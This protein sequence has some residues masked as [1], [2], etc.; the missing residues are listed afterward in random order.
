M[1]SRTTLYLIGI[2]GIPYMKRV[3]GFTDQ[4]L[5]AYAYTVVG[6]YRLLRKLT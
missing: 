4:L 3:K 5:Y 1:L 6:G 2:V